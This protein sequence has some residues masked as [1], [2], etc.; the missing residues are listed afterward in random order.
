[1]LAR[2][3]PLICKALFRNPQQEHER[4]RRAYRC[5][6]S[7]VYTVRNVKVTVPRVGHWVNF[8]RKCNRDKASG[9][10]VILGDRGILP[11]ADQ[12]G[13]TCSSVGSAQ[14]YHGSVR[15]GIVARAGP[16]AAGGRGRPEPLEAFS[17]SNQT[18]EKISRRP[19][20][21]PVASST[22]A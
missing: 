16:W 21:R 5:R 20:P 14:Q 2:A 17:A 18:C 9:G 12:K 11:R 19:F 8:T 22:S 1:M 6:D 13:A 4:R 10:K 15:Y 3:I 7:K